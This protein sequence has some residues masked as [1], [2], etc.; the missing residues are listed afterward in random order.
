MQNMF[1]SVTLS[2]VISIPGLANAAFN[3]TTIDVPGSSKT[4][5]NG[6]STNKIAGEYD[7]ANGYT[8]GFILSKG[9]YTT[10][11]VPSAASTTVNGISANDQFTGT[12]NNGTRNYAYFQSKKGIITTLDP[13]LPAPSKSIESQGGFLNA[14]GNVVGGYRDDKRVRHAFLWSDGFFTTIDPPNGSPTLGPIAFGINDPGQIVGTYVDVN[15]NRHG[16]LLSKG[17]YT[18]LDV[19]GAAFTVAEGINNSGQIVGLYFDTDFNEHGFILSKG[20]YT[21]IDVPDSTATAV[22][23]INAK[24]EIVGSYDDSNG[25]THGYVGR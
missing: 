20:V 13:L 17:V 18:N 6:N 24:G 2:L 8:H 14:Q 25:V 19:P 12:Y 10:I 15:G 11:D 23:S 16:F 3:F 7:D 21:T 1:L 22:F 5:A 9:V 4:I